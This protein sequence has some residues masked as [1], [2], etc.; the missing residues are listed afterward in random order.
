MPH[1]M[2]TETR[3]RALLKANRAVV[4]QLD[5]PTVLRRIVEAAV[6]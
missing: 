6:D 2:T 1:N 5:L 4:E 3:L